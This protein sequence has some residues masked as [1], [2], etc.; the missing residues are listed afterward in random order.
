MKKV[1]TA[2]QHYL[3]DRD[4]SRTRPG[5]NSTI[6]LRGVLVG[7]V[8]CAVIGLGAP[9]TTMLLKGT[10]MGFSSCTPAAFFLLFVLMVSI[11]LLLGLLGKRWAFQR[12]ELLT[13][14][15]MMMVAAALPTRGVTGMLL[16]MI[17]GTFYYATPENQ[18]AELI[19]PHLADWFLVND[20]GAVKGFYEGSADA[21]GIPWS[22]WLPPLLGWALFYAAFYLTVISIMVILRRRWVDEERLPFPI[23]QV[24][25]AIFDEGEAAG[26]VPPFLKNWV[27]WSG[28]ALPMT[29]SSLNALRHYFP[30]LPSI[31]LSTY[32]TPFEGPPLRLG[33]NFLMLG[34]A[35]FINSSISFSLWFFYLIQV[36]QRR[37][38]V[39]VGI[40]TAE[41]QL[42]PWSE[43]IMGHQ[44]M[45]ALIVLVFSGL[46]F[47]RGHL[48]DV[49][50]KTLGRDASVDDS[51]EIMSYR[52][53]ILGTL[54]GTVVMG[55]WL[56][57]SGIP[58]WIAPLFVFATL[59]ILVGLTRV[60]AESGL[61]TISPAMVPAGF[62]VSAVG[63]P[64][65]GTVGMIAT[66]YT[67]IW[68]GELLVF[69]MAPLANGLRLGSETS[70]NRRRLFWSI[71]V[72][73]AIT[74][75]VSVWFT[76]YLAYRHGGVNLNSQF[77][78]G[79][80]TYPSQFAARKL[81]QPTGP[82]L[83]GWLWTLG[84]GVVMTLL[85]IGRHRFS[86]WPLHPLGFAVS[87]GWTMGVI[88]S[89]ILLA[90]AIK[91]V[92][93]KY[94]GA[95][96]YQ[97]TRPFFIGLIMGQFVVAGLWLIVDSIT[98]TVGNVIPVFY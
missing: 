51:P 86:G 22:I 35:Y 53:A 59:V 88:W 26:R 58:A 32:I 43:P 33:V 44:M 68:I 94:G 3:E 20:P 81:T 17:T 45:G 36:V 87:T 71:G 5:Q 63:V 49:W 95:G 29:I 90:W 60:V 65:L 67:L 13:I 9:Y 11:H 80:P 98:G 92:V 55:V 76:L 34:F 77:F 66:G 14:T 21:S 23:A 72:A 61:P 56:W 18:W 1:P 42:G 79:F 41:A 64:A 78:G 39:L 82:S 7:G 50:R 84:G 54:V 19:H 2:Y 30:S 69:M 37:V 12:G 6:T 91:G 89:S 16:P 38:L 40:N 48:R 27:M 4:R 52:S 46:W 97:K 24:P 74:L 25:L 47:G 31:T 62:V 28:F 8:M 96:V 10:R 73:I 83:G 75:V 70:G 15:I 85:L 57:K 93:L